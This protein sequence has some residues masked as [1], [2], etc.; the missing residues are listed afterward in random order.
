MGGRG[1]NFSPARMVLPRAGGG[2]VE[3][4][5]SFIRAIEHGAFTRMAA[6]VRDDN[7]LDLENLW[8]LMLDM[9][10][11]GNLPIA[12]PGGRVTR[13]GVRYER[14]KQ[15]TL[16]K[17]MLMNMGVDEEVVESAL[18]GSVPE[19]HAMKYGDVISRL[20]KSIDYGASTFT[21]RSL[22]G[23]SDQAGTPQVPG[24]GSSQSSLYRLGR[25]Y[26]RSLLPRNLLMR[27]LEAAKRDLQALMDLPGSEFTGLG[28]RAAQEQIA[29]LTELSQK[30]S[31]AENQLAYGP[32]PFTSEYDST[33][34]AQSREAIEMG[35]YGGVGSDTLLRPVSYSERRRELEARLQAMPTE[36]EL[37]L[38]ISALATDMSPHEQFKIMRMRAEREVIE[39]E[40]AHL[41]AP[42]GE[43]DRAK[44]NRELEARAE[45]PELADIEAQLLAI[46]DVAGAG[47]LDVSGAPIF[48]PGIKKPGMGYYDRPGKIFTGLSTH[49]GLSKML[50]DIVTDP[51]LGIMD[52]IGNPRIDSSDPFAVG[53]QLER[54]PATAMLGRLLK[55]IITDEANKRR[56][57]MDTVEPSE[58]A[59][60]TRASKSRMKSEAPPYRAQ[61]EIGDIEAILG[62]RADSGVPGRGLRRQEQMFGE[63]ISGL[64][65][66]TVEGREDSSGST[67]P[68]LRSRMYQELG[69][70]P[71]EEE[72]GIEL[73]SGEGSSDYREAKA[74]LES[75]QKEAANRIAEL[76]GRQAKLRQVMQMADELL[77]K[78]DVETT[79]EYGRTTKK[80]EYNLP[81]PKPGEEGNYDARKASDTVIA[82]ANLKRKLEGAD[83]Q[84]LSMAQEEA[85]RQLRFRDPAH[86]G[87][88]IV[89]NGPDLRTP[90]ETRAAYQQALGSELP[91]GEGFGNMQGPPGGDDGGGNRYGDNPRP[92]SGLLSVWIKGPF[93]LAVR[94]AGRGTEEGET[95]NTVAA[96]S[97]QDAQ[98]GVDA[99]AQGN[100]QQRAVV[101]GAEITAPPEPGVMRQGGRGLM[102]EES[103]GRLLSGEDGGYWASPLSR[104]DTMTDRELKAAGL[105]RQRR[106]PT[107]RG[108]EFRFASGVE[109]ASGPI[110]WLNAGE[111]GPL[112]EQVTPQGGLS[113][114]GNMLSQLEARVTEQARREGRD[115]AAVTVDRE[116]RAA[117]RP[118]KTAMA[119]AA[120][121]QNVLSAMVQE[122]TGRPLA[123]IDDLEQELYSTEGTMETMRKARAVIN[124][125]RRQLPSRAPSTMMVQLSQSLIGGLDKPFEQIAEAEQAMAQLGTI[126][127][128]RRRAQAKVDVSEANLAALTQSRDFY[129]ELFEETKDA[130]FGERVE[131]LTKGIAKEE[132]ALAKAT[133]VRD[134][135]VE[136][137][138]QAT[139]GI[140]KLAQGAVTGGDIL[141][142][143]GAGFIG[144]VA[145]GLT[146]LGIS[147]AIQAIMGGIELAMPAID[148][149][150]GGGMQ[151][152]QM[153][154][155]LTKIATETGGSKSAV[156]T[157]L[158][159]QGF[160]R[161]MITAMRAVTQ[162]ALAQA[163]AQR[164]QEQADTYRATRNVERTRDR[165]GLD[166]ATDYTPILTEAR[167]GFRINPGGGW[168]VGES[169]GG[170]IR[171]VITD[172]LGGQLGGLYMNFNPDQ[173]SIQQSIAR[174]IG[175]M[176]TQTIDAGS[177]FFSGAQWPWDDETI[178]LSNEMLDQFNEKLGEAGDS[179]KIVTRMGGPDDTTKKFLMEAGAGDLEAMLRHRNL[180][181]EGIKSL[182][183]M[184]E[185]LNALNPE[186]PSFSGAFQ[187]GLGSAQLANQ[188]WGIY[189]SR[190]LGMRM[191]AQ[192]AGLNS[193]ANPIMPFGMGTYATGSK[194][195]SQ[196]G[197]IYS[198]NA[199]TA[200]NYEE[201]GLAD[202][203]SMLAESLDP[204]NAETLI[205][206]LKV[207]RQELYDLNMA[208]A[209]IQKAQAW[210]NYAQQVKVAKWQV[211]D[212]VAITGKG[213]GSVIG[214][215]QRE[216]MLLQRRS[217]L[218][219]FQQEQRRINFQVAVAGFNSI[220]LTGE[221]RAMRLKIAQKEA[222]I[223][224]EQ[225][226]INRTVGGNEFQIVQRQNDRALQQATF[227]LQNLRASFAEQQDMAKISQAI[228]VTNRA[229][230]QNLKDVQTLQSAEQQMLELEKQYTQDQANAANTNLLAGK[231]AK[232]AATWWKEGVDQLEKL[233]KGTPG[234]F[235]RS[236]GQS[237]I[238]VNVNVEGHVVD[239]DKL[240]AKV[241]KAIGE[242]ASVGGAVG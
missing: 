72:I 19:T 99:A 82:R 40:L 166:E 176:P 91:T 193:F 81:M 55:G 140:I 12:R 59:R 77:G 130:G 206:D 119:K 207:M 201:A 64:Y 78:H 66:Q 9:D 150:L 135:F 85:L 222:G 61:Q 211:A 218:L 117:Q 62:V 73:A 52:L 212:L 57:A 198:R 44:V 160:D 183:D 39:R 96:S 13:N 155:G 49:E 203:E 136:A 161:E 98:R 221:E 181:I 122:A 232:Q 139:E 41:N 65:K 47:G 126:G 100:A 137:E 120:P 75:Q 157:T 43:E 184:F 191:N 164:L 112:A 14:V 149:A 190:D 215:M 148:Q 20:G 88:N 200:F 17:S 4:P 37:A 33:L 199:E 31:M 196:A 240:T 74:K 95:S 152:N 229:L 231:H 134:D 171:D 146:T 118:S 69:R 233:M 71:T 224:Q 22:R 238:T 195:E 226:D 107:G 50:L 32:M 145:G 89:I 216:N 188:V 158:S 219:G 79:D 169:W 35:A 174:I 105:A 68:G 80:T 76:E 27:Q 48:V 133:K 111:V 167:G 151:V 234:V 172:V 178:V 26:S 53:N 173:E 235:G 3:L 84:I 175:D 128:G 7:S 56:Y 24:T 217:Q 192:S 129:Q 101:A 163:G 46:R 138:E 179:M 189:Q 141:K 113:L 42:L 45:R 144:G 103:Q 180:T 182:D 25:D 194:Y 241:E 93:P 15:R 70:Q 168:Q 170:P 236:G 92:F 209:E 225:L 230:G 239:I 186:V 54:N 227:A 142:N 121:S 205:A 2:E 104:E 11:E 124:Q 197:A 28:G 223:A 156:E 213:E 106:I 165:L 6:P 154:A 187:S 147:T 36:Q 63:Q 208:G 202:L 214:Q 220:G 51:D 30:L 94:L 242:H 8:P 210:R 114:L 153:L 109:P 87:E 131:A 23:A 58:K 1:E 116:N 108:A 5:A 10:E 67:S 110:Q 21:T 228:Q 115:P 90:D 83:E 132:M 162:I 34:N 102:L 60:E 237:A 204:A 38:P 177:G 125:K 159:R 16:L 123:T 86:I 127:A 97:G 143:L 29:Y 185:A 18:S